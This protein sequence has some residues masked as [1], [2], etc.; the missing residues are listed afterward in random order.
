MCE[1]LR[2]QYLLHV[3][4]QKFKIKLFLLFNIKICTVYTKCCK[5]SSS[6]LNM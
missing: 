6:K 1:L 2:N 4:K 5:N 3:Y